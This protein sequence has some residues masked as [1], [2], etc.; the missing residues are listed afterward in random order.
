MAITSQPR[1]AGF[2][3]TFSLPPQ[4]LPKPSWITISQI[5]AISVD[6]LGKRIGTLD[7]QALG[8]AIDG[9]LELIS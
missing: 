5:R 2:P 1:K 3:L 7:P 9:L 4:L 8:E 6:R